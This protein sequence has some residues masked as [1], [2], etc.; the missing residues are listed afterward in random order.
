[1]LQVTVLG[2]A[3]GGGLPQWNCSCLVCKS[4]RTHSESAQTQSSIAVSSDNNNWVLINASPDLRQQFLATKKLH[5]QST[6]R[7]SPLNAVV[8]TNADVDH[9][10]GLLSLREQQR[11]SLYATKRVLNIL[12]KNSIFNVLNTQF[13]ERKPFLLNEEQEIRNGLGKSTGIYIQPFTIPG[14]IALWL[15]DP[16]LKNFGSLPEDTIGLAIRTKD[17]QKR[18]IYL[19]GCAEINDEIISIFRE[20]DTVLFDGTTFS[21]N[22]LI[23][24]GVSE[25]TAS[26]MGHIPMGGEHGSVS[27]LSK[28]NVNRK[29]YIHINNTNPVLLK[30]SIERAFIY[31]NGWELAFDGMEIEID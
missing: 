14:K 29:I 9:V 5:P 22:E 26:R 24:A 17:S 25:K 10:A 4:A 13:V 19:P 21:E 28:V 12:E 23:E 31:E 8:L 2:A 20:T 7:H 27:Q 1:M 30:D 15:E 11:F 18:L 3:A 6:P 16:L